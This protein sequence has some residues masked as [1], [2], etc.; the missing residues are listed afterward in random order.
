MISV[1]L[2]K[3][4]LSLFL[5]MALGFLLVKKKILKAEDS[6]VMSVISLHLIIPCVILSAFQVEYTAQIRD[7]LLL[8]FAASVLLHIVLIVV[9]EIFGKICRMDAVEKAS[10]IY[11]NAANLIMPI[12][13]SV[14]GDEWVIYT[15]AFCSV[16]LILL[17]SHGKMLLCGEKKIDIKKIVTNVNMIAIMIGI[18]L[19]FG[20]LRFPQMVQDSIEMVADTV[21][22]IAMI[23]T[24][25][26]IGGMNFKKIFAYKR[27]W[28]VIVLRLVAVPVLCVLAIKYSGLIGLVPEGETILLITLLPAITPPASTI[29]QMAQIY[30]KD[31]DYASAINVVATLLCIITMP[32]M[33]MLYQM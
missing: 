23:I 25:M 15:S 3:K 31:A 1:I 9:T 12:V 21:G 7:G 29:T 33:V 14:L 19:F 8:A 32:L 10:V 2:A 18:V 17:W 26:L 6:K 27:M 28:L 20:K 5:V 30:G 16:Q 24:G 22:P 11:P 4:I 13:M